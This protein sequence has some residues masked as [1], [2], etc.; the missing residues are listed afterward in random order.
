MPPAEG[1]PSPSVIQVGERQ[2][3]PTRPAIVASGPAATWLSRL[4]RHWLAAVLLG[5]GVILR[6]MA[7]FAYRPALFYIDSVKYLFNS[8]GNDPEG[9]K[10]PLRAVLAVANLDTVIV[11]QH[12][13]AL[14]IAVVLYRLLLR[15]GVSR[16]LSALAIAPILLDAY[17]L[18]MEQTIMPGTLFEGLLVA[19][20]T[21]LLWRPKTSWRAVIVAGLVLGTSATVWQAGEALIPAAALYLLVVGGGWR[22]A[23]SKAA[24]MIVACAIPILAYCTGSYVMTGDFFLSHS[25]VTSLYGRT[26][27]A[28]DCATIK[29]PA[30]ERQL[31]PG[32]KAQAEGSDWL[33]FNGGSPVQADYRTMPR[34]EVNQ[35]ITNFDSSVLTQQPLRVASAYVR[36]VMKLFSVTRQTDAGDPPI[37][38]WQFRDYFPYFTPHATQPEVASVAGQFG[39]GLPRVWRPVAAF[40]RSYQLD[41]GFT[42]GPLLALFALAGLFGSVVAILRRRLD[43]TTQ[44]LALATF[45]FFFLGAGLLLVSDLF[46]FSWRYQI[47]ALVTLVPAGVLGLAVLGRLIGSWRENRQPELPGQRGRQAGEVRE[48]RRPGGRVLARPWRPPAARAR[49]GW[50]A[51]RD[52]RPAPRSRTGRR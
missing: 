48:R 19:A 2:T 15:R 30:A 37:S 20:F 11:L 6:V 18:Q 3:P 8:Q 50:P 22:H 42:P 34:A 25:G 28:V 4:R 46:V 21:I 45:L 9:Y 5:L 7:Q 47:Q 1:R 44:Q 13:L 16:W 27:S 51:R 39:G 38:R 35:L 36:D 31:C 40:L 52:S 29:L 49:P 12:L 23:L 24:V 14:A 17:Q 10:A 33:Q 41:G 43:E 26:A 32:Q